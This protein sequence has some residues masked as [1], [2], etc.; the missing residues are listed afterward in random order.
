MYFFCAYLLYLFML[1]LVNT[2]SVKFK[3]SNDFLLYIFFSFL[4][5][6]CSMVY[7]MQFNI[8]IYFWFILTS[9][10]NIVIYITFI[11]ILN[12]T[13][14]CYNYNFIYMDV[15]WRWE[16]SSKLYLQSLL[17]W[18]LNNNICLS[19]FVP[20]LSPLQLCFYAPLLFFYFV[21]WLNF[22]NKKF[23]YTNK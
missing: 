22:N 8:R 20:F 10:T 18:H 11:Y 7:H 6:G 16:L 15:F 12:P 3:F 9:I 14:D 19:W 1:Y 5:S 23:Y 21:F 13:T 17:Y 2:F 4:V